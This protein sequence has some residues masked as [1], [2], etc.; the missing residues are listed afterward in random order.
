MDARIGSSEGQYRVLQRLPAVIDI[1]RMRGIR[2]TQFEVE[3]SDFAVRWPC[4][5]TTPC[6]DGEPYCAP[7]N[8]VMRRIATLRFSTLEPWV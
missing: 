4:V 5:V 8:G 3:P 1:D 7:S 2:M 6:S